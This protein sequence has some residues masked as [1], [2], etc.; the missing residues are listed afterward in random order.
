MK[1]DKTPQQFDP[2]HHVQTLV[3]LEYTVNC[4]YVCETILEDT[5]SAMVCHT[6]VHPY[7]ILGVF[8]RSGVVADQRRNM[9]L[10]HI[11]HSAAEHVHIYRLTLSCNDAIL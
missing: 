4:S 2:R 10:S 8:I 7:T 11:M 6:R 9:S 1:H 5:I 3:Y